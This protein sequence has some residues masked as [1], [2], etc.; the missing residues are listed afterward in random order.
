M[1]RLLSC[2]VFKLFVDRL[3]NHITTGSLRMVLLHRGASPIES[4][5][6]ALVSGKISNDGPSY[7]AGQAPRATPCGLARLPYICHSET[8]QVILNYNLCVKDSHSALKD[9]MIYDGIIYG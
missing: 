6:R 7:R 1:V 3:I 9:E 2:I 8:Y 5:K 4:L